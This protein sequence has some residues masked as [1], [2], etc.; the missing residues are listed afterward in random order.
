MLLLYEHL[1]VRSARLR[2]ELL[3]VRVCVEL[4]LV[5]IL[6]AQDVFVGRTSFV[7]QKQ[8]VDAMNCNLTKW[9]ARPQKEIPGLS[10]TSWARKCYRRVVSGHIC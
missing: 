9:T 7:R 4:R 8:V 3:Y 10:T 5:A 6:G 1:N 2:R